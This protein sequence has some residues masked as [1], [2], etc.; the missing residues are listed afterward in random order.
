MIIPTHFIAHFRV[1]D[2]VPPSGTISYEELCKKLGKNGGLPVEKTKRILRFGMVTQHLFCEPEIG[3]I[4]HT[5]FSLALRS[6][7]YGIPAVS[8]FFINVVENHIDSV[9]H[10][11]ESIE[12][13]GKEEV[14]LPEHAP[15]AIGYGGVSIMEYLGECRAGRQEGDG[16]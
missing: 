16:C 3:Y 8:T 9:A 7:G 10:F 14:E 4:A 2:Y 11:C 6:D 1:A 15:G 13:Y 12:K 5:S